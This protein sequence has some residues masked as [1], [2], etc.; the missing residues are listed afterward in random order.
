MIIVTSLMF[1]PQIF[2]FFL[3]LY[4]FLTT[5]NSLQDLSL[6]AGKDGRQKEKETAEN[7]MVGEHH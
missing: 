4:L 7:E 5:L 3:L 2:F 1:H 6:D